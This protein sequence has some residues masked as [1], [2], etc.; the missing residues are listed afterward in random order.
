[1]KKGTMIC[2]LNSYRAKRKTPQGY[3]SAGGY[4]DEGDRGTDRERAH[5]ATHA[6]IAKMGSNK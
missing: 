6:V 5:R 3:N 1:M 4:N 2:G